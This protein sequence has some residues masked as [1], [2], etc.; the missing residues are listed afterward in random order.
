MDKTAKG[1]LGRMR[2]AV[3]P[4]YNT[5]AGSY[6]DDI[7]TPV[8]L[9]I[10]KAYALADENIKRRLISTSTGKDLQENLEEIGFF[11][12][13][14]SYASGQV[15]LTGAPG[16]VVAPGSLV[17]FGKV[18]YEINEEALIGED[19][20]AVCNVV[21]SLP[22]ASGN[23]APGKINYFPVTL[24]NI[25]SVTN[26][27]YI[28]GG[29]D[30]ETDDEYKARY[31]YFVDHPPISGNIYE[32][33]QLALEADERVRY[34]KAYEVWNGPGTVK[35]VIAGA[36][37]TPLGSDIVKIVADYIEKKRVA[38]ADVTVVS[39]ETEPISVSA[40]VTLKSGVVIDDV[41]DD[42]EEALENYLKELG[43]KSRIVAVSQIGSILQ[44]VAGVEF[45]TNLLINGATD[46][47]E[48]P[49][50]KLVSI[51]GVTLE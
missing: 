30:E 25:T 34:A 22:G 26:E 6:V 17:A 44:G 38:G 40:D 18:T 13:L 48:I 16:A 9:E 51:G 19:G 32:Y 8:A 3:D 2:A 28:T 27:G 15:K 47:I 49:E 41:A 1:I 11:K 24:P 37:L 4:K 50:A 10:E 14:S 46:N 20:T 21:A 42:F 35:V 33:E 36:E 45:Y 31:Y 12:K 43:F 5:A 29:A 39:A 23:A 7:L